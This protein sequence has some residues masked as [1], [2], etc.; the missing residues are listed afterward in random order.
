[1]RSGTGPGVVSRMT[2]S[3]R[4][5]SR[6]LRVRRNAVPALWA[7]GFLKPDPRTRVAPKAHLA[8]CLWDPPEGRRHRQGEHDFCDSLSPPQDL[9]VSAAKRVRG[10]GPRVRATRQREPGAELQVSRV[11]LEALVE[12]GA[13]RWTHH[14]EDERRSAGLS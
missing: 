10:A 7:C 11:E 8:D 5:Q 4:A 9:P 1:M 13:A 6:G 14:R 3:L 12:V 2:S